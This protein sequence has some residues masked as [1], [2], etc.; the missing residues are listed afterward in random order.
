METEIND[1]LAHVQRHIKAGELEV[2]RKICKKLL[3]IH[4]DNKVVD[5]LYQKL[6]LE[7]KFLERKKRFTTKVV[8]G[9]LEEKNAN[10]KDFGVSGKNPSGN[11]ESKKNNLFIKPI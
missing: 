3:L 1:A 9:L 11:F 10:F 5:E 7:S 6:M 4:P 8:Q 2:A